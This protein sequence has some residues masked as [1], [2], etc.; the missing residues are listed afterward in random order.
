[1]RKV[2]R[3]FG[4]S[5]GTISKWVK[6]ARVYGYNPIP[7]LPSNA[8]SHP[9]AISKEKERAIVWKRLS[10]GRSA[11]VI[12]RA[13]QDDGI[14]VSLSS[15]K[16]TLARNNLL[17][18]RSP[19]KRRHVSVPRPDAAHPGDLVE[20]DTIHLQRRDGSKVYVFTGLDV[21]T[22]YAHAWAS[23]RANARTSVMFLKRMKRAV[24]FQC[25]M[26]QSDNGPEFSTH[27]T[28]RAKVEHRHS[29]VRRPNDNAH[30]E[31][32]NRTI[33]EEL[34]DALPKDA[35]AINRAL[36]QYLRWYNTKRHHFG[37]ALETPLTAVKCFQGAD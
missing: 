18:K 5:P 35:V 27:F 2:A 21:K 7:T 17:K 29:R 1:M 36:P 12:Q 30:L 37:L 4:V 34:L 26:L 25:K 8:K 15:V 6:K 24:P 23:E 13:L 3:R 10:L 20:L 28:E 19:W 16:R 31:R 33:Q 22:R 9:N 11:E 14:E 32:F